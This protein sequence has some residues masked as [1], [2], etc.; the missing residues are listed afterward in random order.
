MLVNGQNV[1]VV[2]LDKGRQELILKLL[3]KFYRFLKKLNPNGLFKGVSS[4][5]GA[6]IR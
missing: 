5:Q 2:L 4:T 6:T 3:S 1:A